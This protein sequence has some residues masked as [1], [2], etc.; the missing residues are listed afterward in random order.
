MEKSEHPSTLWGGRFAK[1]I[2]GDMLAFSTSLP[3]DWR[4]YGEDIAGSLAHCR[5]L[6]KQ[7][8]ISRE[9]AD[10]VCTGLTAILEGI[11]SGAITPDAERWED[12]HSAV[13]D[14]LEERV[15]AAAG[16]LHTARSRN[17]QV[18]TDV[19]LWCRGALDSLG[20]QLCR[21]QETLL[22]QAAAH[23]TTAMPG[24][25]HL[26]RAQPVTFGHH[27]LAYVEMLSR[28]FAR[29]RECRTRVNV[30]PLGAAALA[31]APYPLDREYVARELGFAAIAANS[32]DA[33]SDRDFA[34]EVLH[35]C[36]QIMVHLSRLASEVI[37]WSSAEFGFVELDDA[38]ATGSSIMPQKKN[39]DSAELT[40]GKAGRVFGDLFSLLTLM[41]GLPLTYNRDLQEDKEALFD[42][43]DTT[44]ACLDIMNAV[45]GTLRVEAARMGEAAEGGFSTATDLADYLVRKGLPFREAHAVVGSIVRLCLERGCGLADLSLAEYQ[46]VC[47][48]IS[49]EVFDV[50]SVEGSIAAR[51]IPGGTA[52]VQVIAAIEH[53][54]ERLRESRSA[55]A[56][57]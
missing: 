36:S 34:I 28:D 42:G 53:A 12:V 31:G 5:M 15:G 43:V 51:D 26:Q 38:Y 22:D 17:D 9:D 8:I 52:P 7:D 57:T 20:Q 25:T 48:R 4:L 23:A 18:A 47:N 35:V 3:V 55:L 19:R 13:E 56:N 50:I 2:A 21:F 33:V 16:K 11:E 44:V 6:A 45:L 39:P 54:R 32:M 27:L 29:S 46:E 41:E 24:Y 37:L 40:R 30:L 10:A 1:P 14:L 49:A